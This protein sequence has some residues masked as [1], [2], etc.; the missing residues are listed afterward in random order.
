[1]YNIQGK[2]PQKKT[3]V[4]LGSFGHIRTE[5]TEGR[6]FVVKRQHFK[7]RESELEGWELANKEEIEMVLMEVTIA[8]ICSTLK[9]GPELDL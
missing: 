8:K 6:A 3:N 7:R 2:A 4:G 5:H 9:I 1:M